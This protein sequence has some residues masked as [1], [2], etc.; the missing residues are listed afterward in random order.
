MGPEETVCHI[1]PE[2][3]HKE[4]GQLEAGGPAEEPA[5]LARS[6]LGGDSWG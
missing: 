4:E 5:G 2:C 1:F 3:Y 6:A